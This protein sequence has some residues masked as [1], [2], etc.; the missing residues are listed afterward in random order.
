MVL[1][2]HMQSQGGQGLHSSL[3]SR[4]LFLRLSLPESERSLLLPLFELDS[5]LPVL[6]GELKSA[7][8]CT[9]LLQDSLLG[10]A[11]T[12]DGGRLLAS[13]GADRIGMACLSAVQHSTGS[14]AL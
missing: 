9:S 4:L 7:S 5:M 3:E 1:N 8:R 6:T 14:D 12:G 13:V 10:L 11:S 2:L